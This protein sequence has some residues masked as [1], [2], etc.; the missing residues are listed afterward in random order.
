[1]STY[2]F[3]EEKIGEESEDDLKGLNK[4]SFSKA[5]LWATDWTTET[6]ISQLKKG[7]IE[8]SPS[9]QR[10]D[11]W[12]ADRKSKFIE[13]I[14]LGLPIP[15]IIL[16]ER[17][18][19][20]NSYVVIDGKQRLLSI[21]Q[22]CANEDEEDFEPLYLKKLGILKDLNNKKFS[23][24]QAELDFSQ[25][26]SAFE[27][28]SIRTVI[29]RNWPN[30]NFLY[31][32]FLRLNTGSL[33]LSPQEL[34]QALNPG[35]FTSFADTFSVESEDVKEALGLKKPDYRMRD[36]EIVVRYFA[37]KNFFETYTGNLKD[38]LD[39]TCENLNNSWEDDHELINEQA[40]QL[41]KAIK[42]TFNIFGENAFS[43]F[44]NGKYTGIF[45]RPVYDIMTY[46]FSS[47][48]IR[49]AA[50]VNKTLVVGKFEE[51]CTTDTE[52]LRSLET[53]T[54]NIDPTTKRFNTWGATL[55]QLLGIGFL[56]PV[57]T[58]NG[59]RLQ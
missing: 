12:G 39:K 23:T 58:E 47:E 30:Q 13:S 57:R 7:N 2:D 38:F 42:A 11:A 22:F 35:P 56:L 33:P 15:Q 41:N 52:F 26:T 10:R 24:V 53:S 44:A 5:V 34:R 19:K 54:K 1:M 9:F 55:K 43:K 48:N 14:F 59:I 16:A 37:F 21:R 32:V 8:L 51:L 31:T 18:D 25:Y 36:V 6:I 17:R 40:Y 50:I 4:D 46:Y 20:K 29:I 49:D 27:N 28:Q 3:E 45:N